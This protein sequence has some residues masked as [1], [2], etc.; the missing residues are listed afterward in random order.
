MKAAAKKSAANLRILEIV[1][2]PPAVRANEANGSA[3]RDVEVLDV[4]SLRKELAEELVDRSLR[5]NG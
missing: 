1:E 2:M 5:R 3:L 4:M